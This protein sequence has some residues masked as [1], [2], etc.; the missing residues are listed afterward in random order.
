MDIK[1]GIRAAF[2]AAK[3]IVKRDAGLFV[4]APFLSYSLYC[5]SQNCL[6]T[7]ILFMLV[8]Y[9]AGGATHIFTTC[10]RPNGK[11]NLSSGPQI[12]S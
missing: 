12:A 4:A 1:N 5:L 10:V 8:G 11:N 7:G 3:N 9:A 6:M 2:V